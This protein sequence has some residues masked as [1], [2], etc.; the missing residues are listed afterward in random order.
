MVPRRPDKSENRLR[1]PGSRVTGQEGINRLE[2]AAG[3]EPCDFVGSG[4]QTGVGIESREWLA[5]GVCHSPDI[6]RVVDE[7]EFGFGR[8]P[9]VYEG[10]TAEFRV[11]QVMDYAEPIG[12]LGMALT[13]V[14]LEIAVVLDESK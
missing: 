3:G 6:E 13:G 2:Q 1:C 10:K 12:A 14:V 5:L 8:E 4:R 9:R 7:G 11:Y